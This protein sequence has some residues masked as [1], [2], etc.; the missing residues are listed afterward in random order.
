MGSATKDIYGVVLA[1]Y[2][3]NVVQLQ[4]DGSLSLAYRMEIRG[5]PKGPGTLTTAYEAQEGCVYVYFT[6]DS[7]IS[8][9]RV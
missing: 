2:Y 7:G 3:L 6:T 4:D 1:P 9:K 8:C 5:C